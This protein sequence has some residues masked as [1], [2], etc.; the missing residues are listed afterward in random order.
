MPT[1]SLKSNHKTIKEYYCKLQQLDKLGIAN[2][3]AVQQA[4]E[5]VLK[6][7]CNQLNWT[8]A[9]QQTFKINQQTIRPEGV[10][11]RQDT[12]KHGYWEAKDNK[13]D[14]AKE[15]SQKFKAGY[16]KNN[17]LFWQPKRIILYQNNQLVFDEKIDTSEH[18]ISAIQLFFEYSQP[19]IEEWEQASINFGQKVQELGKGLLELIETQKKINKQFIVAF[20][21]FTKL[22]QQTINPNISEL[23]IEEM[24][25]Q[26]LLTERIFRKLFNNPDFVKRNVIA[27]EIEKVIDTLT[28]KSF[29]RDHFLQE[30]DY[31]YKALENAASTITEYSEK[32]DF[33]N[34]V[35]E[36]FFQG[37]AVKVADT[38]GIVYTPQPL[39]NF[40]VKSVEDILQKEF[41][42]SLSDK[43][44]HLLDPFVGTGNFLMG[45]M[46]EIRKTS[47]GYKYENELHCNEVML[48]PYY[49]ASMNIEHEYFTATGEYKPFN[50]ICFV[51]TF[52]VIEKRQ[53]SLFTEENTARVE[54]QK[55]SNIFVII[56]NPPYNAWQI[57]D[58]D[59]NKNR[60]YQE[61]DRRVNETYAKDSKAKLKISLSDPYI[62]AIRWASDRIKDEGI[63]AFLTNNGFIDNLAC[64]GVRKHLQQDFNAIY[65]L[66]LKGNVRKDSMREGIAIGEKHT[67]F[68][69]SA[70]VGIS[71]TFL[72]KH[73]DSNEHKIFYSE[74]DWKA[75]RK[76]KFALIEKAKTCLNLEWK[77]LKPDAKYNW[78]TEGLQ[79]DFETFFPIGDKVAK[80]QKQEQGVIFK[81][82]SNGVKTQRDNWVYNF[83]ENELTNNIEKMLLTYEQELVKSQKNQEIT[84]NDQLISWSLRLKQYLKNKT[85]INFEKSKMRVAIYRPF[86]RKFL[87]FDNYLIDARCLFPYIFPNPETETENKVICLTDSGSEKPFM[88][89]L[90]NLIP[91]L[92]LNGAG[93]TTQCF[94]FYT[95]NKEGKNRQENITDWVL[96]EYQN[97]YQNETP[98][99]SRGVGGDSLTKWDIFH[100]IYA[101]LHHP[102]Y[103]KRYQANLKRELPRIPFAPDFYPFV[104][105]GKKLA[106][107]HLNYENQPE[108][109]LKWIEN[110][111][112]PLY[113]RVEKMKLSK[114]KTKI[115][116]NDFLTL[117]GIPKE[118][119][120]YKLGHKSALE[121]LIDQYQI[122]T[123]KRSGIINDPNKLEDEEYIVKLIGKIITVSLET[124]KIVNN[125]PNLGL[126]NIDQKSAF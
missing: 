3:G 86:T 99:L 31:F 66:D 103:T 28:S 119:F 39:V 79:D 74:V 42:K 100:Y 49:L 55:E 56:G 107:L 65:I 41:N 15:V 83:D 96:K 112:I 20:S 117:K 64:D 75:T 111:E 23:A 44:V 34:K 108:Y 110:Q 25:I 59:N 84:T 68:G 19:E 11:F 101:I 76:E 116:Y 21:N 1:L 9:A 89:L 104:E 120:E 27:V 63:V 2:E 13:D 58:N 54:T 7:C 8:Y 121:W 16:P 72:V 52:E 87:Y 14:L 123:D 126:P 97:Y 45:I 22:C 67:I 40:M 95:Y 115:K 57:N 30:V 98:P 69:L 50:G 46:R 35:Y 10:I 37:F 90:T 82:F 24:L 60:K 32:Q 47:L 6:T 77:S 48:L 5:D 62:K 93:C 102:E 53:L 92:H 18:L 81:T 12:L 80:K 78:L 51:D 113:W 71:V 29:N 88:V 17:L 114:D 94:P 61:I 109:S 36:R 70:M 122:K 26:H 124:V 105:A 33:L 85:E 43:G 73:K 91:D 38:H 125:L 106:H 118:V 4:F